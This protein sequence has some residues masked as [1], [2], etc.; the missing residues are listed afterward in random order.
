V[1]NAETKFVHEGTPKDTLTL[2]PG[3]FG[4]SIELFA[5]PNVDAGTHPVTVT[6]ETPSGMSAAAVVPLRA[7]S[8]MEF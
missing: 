8:Y 1:T 7:Q 6:A 2:D 4:D 5:N 3:D